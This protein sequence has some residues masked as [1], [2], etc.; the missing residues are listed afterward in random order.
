MI[1]TYLHPYSLCFVFYIFF[2]LLFLLLNLPRNDFA[3]LRK[4]TFA[5]TEKSIWK[6]CIETIKTN[7]ALLCTHSR[8]TLANADRDEIKEILERE[9]KIFTPVILIHIRLLIC[10]FRPEAVDLFFIFLKLHELI[11]DL[12]FPQN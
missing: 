2:L 8:I 5:H 12:F 6:E 7:H 1:K 9:K 3:F 4:S 11:F 10:C